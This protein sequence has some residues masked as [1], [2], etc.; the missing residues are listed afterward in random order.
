MYLIEGAIKKSFLIILFVRNLVYLFVLL[1]VYS[2]LSGKLRYDRNL[3]QFGI[4][5]IIFKHW[6][7]KWH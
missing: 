3:E 4:S 7:F 2:R 1:I 6:E 5:L